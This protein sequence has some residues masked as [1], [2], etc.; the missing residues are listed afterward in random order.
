MKVKYE[1][2]ENTDLMIVFPNVLRTVALWQLWV[3]VGIHSLPQI[4][5]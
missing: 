4:C 1:H 3:Q 2:F 5:Q